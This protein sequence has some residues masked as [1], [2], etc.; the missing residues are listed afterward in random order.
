MLLITDIMQF[1]QRQIKK[2]NNNFVRKY[3]VFYNQ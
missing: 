2:K 3:S 1:T